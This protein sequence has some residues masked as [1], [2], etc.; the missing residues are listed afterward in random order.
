MPKELIIRPIVRQIKLNKFVNVSE[1]KL[2]QQI[3]NEKE[4]TQEKY[5]KCVSAINGFVS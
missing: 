5:Q 2:T 4:H 3:K 1:I